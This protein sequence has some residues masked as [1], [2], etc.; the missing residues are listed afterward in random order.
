MKEFKRK[1]LNTK[2][3]ANKVLEEARQI[4]SKPSTARKRSLEEIFKVSLYG[5]SAEQYLIEKCGFTDDNQKY[6]DV[7]SPEG[8]PVEIKVTQG[9]YYVYHVLQRCNEA[10]REAWRNYPDWVFIYTNNKENDHYILENTYKWN[11]KRFS[12]SNWENEIS[13]MDD[14]EFLDNVGEYLDSR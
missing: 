11:G 6:K 10:K 3:L 14:A 2:A 13:L 1:D 9:Q 5:L 8:I 7:V 12:P 4:H